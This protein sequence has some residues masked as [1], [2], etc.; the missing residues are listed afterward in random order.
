V[1]FFAAGDT[2]IPAVALPPA[3][4]PIVTPQPTV[5]QAQLSLLDY[6]EGYIS[7]APDHDDDSS[8]IYAAEHE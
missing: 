6:V 7:T 5:P 4:Q 1:H 8:Y 3:P 2:Q